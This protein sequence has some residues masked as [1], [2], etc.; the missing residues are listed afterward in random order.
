MSTYI[1]LKVSAPVC[2]RPRASVDKIRGEE[3]RPDQTTVKGSGLHA[4]LPLTCKRSTADVTSSVQREVWH[5][6]TAGLRWLSS[7]DHGR[8]WPL[9][10]RDRIRQLVAEFDADLCVRAAKEAREIVASQDRAPNIT[11]LFEKKLRDLAEVRETVR[12]ELG[13]A[14]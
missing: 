6:L 2:R 7:N 11:G 5:H 9:P 1:P 12:R 13:E 8:D 14:A 3:N 10:L 4:Y